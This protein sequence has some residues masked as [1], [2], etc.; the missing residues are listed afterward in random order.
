VVGFVVGVSTWAEC[1]EN[2]DEFH[3]A[4]SVPDK[5][6]MDDGDPKG[7][8]GIFQKVENLALTAIIQSLDDMTD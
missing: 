8:A 1:R 6:V 7:L 3:I 5:F 2:V 4:E